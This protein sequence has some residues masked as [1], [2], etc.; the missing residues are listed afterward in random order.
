MAA[1]EPINLCLAHEQRTLDALTTPFLLPVTIITGFLGSGKTTLLKSLLAQKRNLRIATLVN[2]LGAFNHDVQLLGL[3]GPTPSASSAH[4]HAARAPP[5]GSSSSDRMIDL[6]GNCVCCSA[7]Q[8]DMRAGVWDCLQTPDGEPHAI[9]YLV[10][11]TS[12][13]TDPEAIVRALDEKFGKMTRARLDSVVTVVDAD[14]LYAEIAGPHDPQQPPPMASQ[15][16]RHQLECAD[17]VLLNKVDLLPEAAHLDLVEQH[18]RTLNPLAHV[19]R[20]RYAE[21]PL[22]CV[23]DVALPDVGVGHMTHETGIANYTTRHASTLRS[24]ASKAVSAKDKS[25]LLTG[26]PVAGSNGDAGVSHL[27]TDGLS[28]FTFTSAHPLRLPKLQRFFSHVF[29]AEA[30]VRCKG[31]LRVRDLPGRRVSLSLSGRRRFQL[32]DEGRWQSAPL[33]QL[34]FI[35]R[36]PGFD[37][38]SLEAALREACQEQDEEEEDKDASHATH[39]LAAQVRALVGQDNRMELVDPADLVRPLLGRPDPA[40][41]PLP[42]WVEGLVTFRLT[43]AR[44]LNVSAAHLSVQ[45][46]VDLDVL[47]RA[48]QEK[49]NMAGQPKAPLLHTLPYDEGSGAGGH[50]GGVALCFAVEA[51]AEDQGQGGAYFAGAWAGIVAHA[52]AVIKQHMSHLQL[53]KCGH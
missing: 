1:A 12:G 52:N 7:L 37:Q 32:Q 48:L 24:E 13:V 6:H 3:P 4:P 18:L 20:T 22:P 43:G 28:T 14:V 38:P 19:H 31:F 40:A 8:Q 33:T 53:C 10:I 30:V 17:V 16:R 49:V 27:V 45:H 36:G 50:A 42:S 9:D 47:N 11:E 46:G 41:A 44:A 2:D 21:V 25:S 23:L 39:Q 29:P 51:G 35:G 15:A 26:K 5:P 34:V